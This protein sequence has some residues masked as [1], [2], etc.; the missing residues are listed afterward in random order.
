MEN[1]DYRI[2]SIE[3]KKNNSTIIE[4]IAAKGISN[5][6]NLLNIFNK[7]YNY[8]SIREVQIENEEDIPNLTFFIKEGHLCHDGTYYLGIKKTKKPILS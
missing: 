5:A 3:S 1:E 4:Y 7:S 8:E 6:I 2:Y